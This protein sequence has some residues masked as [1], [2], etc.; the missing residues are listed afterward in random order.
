MP[1]PASSNKVPKARSGRTTTPAR[2]R[3]Q[4]ERSDAMRKRLVDA[5][6]KCLASDGYSGTTVS[7]I[8]RRAGVSRGAQLHHFS[9]K[10]ALIL[11][12]A[13][14]LLRRAYKTLGDLLLGIA[15][16]EHRLQALVT[17]AW[18]EIFDNR[19]FNAFF[20]LLIA[21]Q[22]DAELARSLRKLFSSA[23]QATQEPIRH[24][25]E[26]KSDH[27]LSPSDLFVMTPLLMSGLAAVRHLVD[28]PLVTRRHLETWTA[29]MLG[30][31]R[32]RK[33][34]NTPPPRPLNWDANPG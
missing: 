17:A 21:S 34:V 32:A 33:G 18:A 20:E 9:T 10:N 26:P 1:Q 22:H 2:R 6:L 25:F 16:E 7:S 27:S 15:Q 23:V 5:T 11:A 4:G 13:D 14:H 19:S 12:A 29:L 28:D 3:T 24:Y 30:Q 31:M 8:V